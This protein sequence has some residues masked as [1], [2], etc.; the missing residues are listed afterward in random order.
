MP[1][2]NRYS[3]DNANVGVENENVGTAILSE[4]LA[5]PKS[6]FTRGEPRTYAATEVRS[7]LSDVN[8]IHR[9]HQVRPQK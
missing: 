1:T 9:V 8:N 7:R 4:K 5:A 6:H 3:S 2:T